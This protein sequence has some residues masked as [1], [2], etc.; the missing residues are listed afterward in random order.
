MELCATLPQYTYNGEL[1]DAC[2]EPS[3]TIIGNN[4]QSQM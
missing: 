4:Y 3:G 2:D 1:C